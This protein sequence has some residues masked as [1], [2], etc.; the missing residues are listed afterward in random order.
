M[1]TVKVMEP[2]GVVWWRAMANR[3]SRITNGVTTHT[4]TTTPR[5]LT[6]KTASCRVPSERG[7]QGHARLFVFGLELKAAPNGHNTHT[8]SRCLTRTL[9]CSGTAICMHDTLQPAFVSRWLMWRRF[10]ENDSTC[11]A[12]QRVG[13]IEK[14][15]ISHARRER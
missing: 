4:L 7:T 13:K 6:A 8:H 9:N 3:E 14:Y 5:T 11:Y 15:V 10:H 1:R 2:G 12:E